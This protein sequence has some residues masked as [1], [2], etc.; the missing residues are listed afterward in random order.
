MLNI[1]PEGGEF[2]AA[3]EG[4]T[5]IAPFRGIHTRPD[6]RRYNSRRGI[7]RCGSVLNSD[8]PSSNRAAL[9]S[10]GGAPPP[11]R[12]PASAFVSRASSNSATS[13]SSHNPCILAHG[14]GT[15][16]SNVV[17]H[18]ADFLSFRYRL[19]RGAGVRLFAWPFFG[20]L[21]RRAGRPSVVNSQVSMAVR[22]GKAVGEF[23]VGVIRHAR[24]CHIHQM[25]LKSPRSARVLFQNHI[26]A[27]MSDP[28]NDQHLFA[29]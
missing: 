7:T 27:N 16:C 8:T 19:E 17:E 20:S 11:T 12:E 2:V 3:G 22:T 10:R 25:S 24:F 6:A 29:A 21:L 18:F 15:P 1:R 13:S 9:R 23:M 5:V 4:Q 28:G 14:A 26:T